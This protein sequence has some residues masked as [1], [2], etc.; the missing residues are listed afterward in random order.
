MD[1]GLL[2]HEWISKSGG[3]EKVFA[4]LVATFPTADLRVLWSDVQAPFGAR[5]VVESWLA[6]TPLRKSKAA[7]LPFMVGAWRRLPSDRPYDWMLVSSHLFAHHAR[8]RRGSQPFV[9]LVYVHTPARYIWT[10]ELDARGSGLV[11][12]IA[13]TFLKPLDRRRAA[14]ASEIAANSEYVRER[15]RDTWGL[16]ARVIYPPVDTARIA[17]GAPWADR[18]DEDEAGL[19]A[20]L[21]EGFVLGASRFIPYKRLELAIKA[22]E[23]V[24]RPVVIAGSGPEEARLRDAA[25]QAE[26]PVHFVLKPSDALLFALYERASVYVFPAVEDFGIMPVEAMACGTPVIANTVGGAGESVGVCGGGVLLDAFDRQSLRTAIEAVQ[27]IDRSAL[28]E[29]VGRFSAE[30]FRSEIR[31]WVTSSMGRAAT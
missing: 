21:P 29:R 15:I 2:V 19:L 23:S 20:S 28:R 5:R 27:T 3:S 7:A 1:G 12:R 17:H 24:G 14:E 6:R 9:K 11:A 8:L 16:D 26:V 25:A 22:G 4:E 30:R 10:P 13:S 31:E 18:L